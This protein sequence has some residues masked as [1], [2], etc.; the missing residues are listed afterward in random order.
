MDYE[1]KLALAKEALDSGSYDKET[2]EYIFPELKESEDER[3]RKELIAHCRNTRCVTEEGAER[4]AKW[5]AWLEKQ[6]EQETADKV[7]S[8]FHV[9]EWIIFNENQNSVYQVEKIDNCRYYLRHYLGGTFSVHFDNELIRRWTIEDAWNGDILYS[10]GHNLLWLHKNTEQCH[11]CINRYYNSNYISFGS[12]IVIPS[13]VC[14]ATKEQRDLL[15]QKIKEAGYEWEAEKKELKLLITNGGDF[16]TKICEQNPVWSEEDEKMLESAIGAIGISDYYTFDDKED[17]VHWLK[18][19]KNRIQAKQ[20]FIE[21]GDDD[22]WSEEDRDYFDAIIAKLEVTQNDALLTDNQME[23]LKSLKCRI[24]P[25]QEWSEK[26]EETFLW[27]CRIV[28]SQR[29]DKVIT[30]KEESELGEWMD[31]WLNHKPQP[32]W[33][34]TDEQMYILNWVANILLH[35]DGIVEEAASKKLQSLY[36]DLKNLKEG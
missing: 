31:K 3:I 18:S 22:A 7:E 23:F 4:I 1:N 30:L 29:V 34:P 26:D 5:I 14:P 17:I 25:Q 2:I 32:H 35:H 9:G 8:K 24:Q 21:E 27:L 19:I 33:K 28:H 15:F 12:K 36:N 13:D 16:D 20:E 6:G 11:C 10:P